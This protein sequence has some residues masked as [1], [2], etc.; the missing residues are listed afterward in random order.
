[1]TRSAIQLTEWETRE[2]EQGSPLWGKDLSEGRDIAEELRRRRQLVVVELVRGLELRASSWVG[3][4]E[5]GELTVTIQPKIPGAPFLHL[6]RYAYG[7][8]QLSV[9]D[10]ALYGRERGTFQD[11]VA[12]QLASEVEELIARGLHR[13]Y[14]RET[15]DLAVPSGRIDFQRYVMAAG[16]GRASLPCAHHPRTRETMLNRVLLAGTL[17][18]ARATD[19]VELRGQLRRLGRALDIDGPP[20]RL[21]W[22]VLDRSRRSIDRRTR[23]YEPALSLICLLMEGFGISLSDGA[24]ALRLPGFLFDMNRFF[25]ALLSRF[26]GDNMRGYLVRDEHRLKGMFTFAP[27]GNPRQRRAPTPRPDFVVLS[28]NRI[29]S[30]LDA[31]Y[32]D[33]WL[34]SLPREMLYQLAMYALSRSGPDRQ[35]VILYPTLTGDAIDQT[36]VLNEPVDGAEKARIVLRPVELL[37]LERLV[38]V[39][40]SV[41][42]ERQCA[43]LAKRLV[44]GRDDATEDYRRGSVNYF[45]NRGP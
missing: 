27:G 6:L 26:L 44:F 45:K 30:V 4:V 35:A 9:K 5:L 7:L 33:L 17:L 39:P 20:P 28:G 1:M 18:A 15:A 2:P 19:D 21:N 8:R 24:E 38:S 37:E 10:Q 43:A 29:A 40:A 22:D 31:K 32:R 42:R 14:R 12:R 11:L 16:G 3:R 41:K 36:I 13:D 23:A 34:H 25:Q